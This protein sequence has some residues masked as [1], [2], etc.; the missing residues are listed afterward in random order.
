MLRLKAL[1]RWVMKLSRYTLYLAG[2][3]LIIMCV[4]AFTSLPFWA[5]YRLGTGYQ[6]DYHTAKTL[7]ILGGGGYPSESTLMRLW[8]TNEFAQRDPMLKVLIS[9]PGKIDDLSSTVMKM[10]QNLIDNGIDSTRIILEPVGLNTRHQAL[11]AFELYKKGF[12]EEPLVL[13]SSPE[14]IFRSVRCFRKVGF[15]EVS[16]QPTLE[17]MLETDLKITNQKLGGKT[18]VPNVG[19]SIPLRYSFWNYLKYEVDVAREYLAIAYYK[20]KGWI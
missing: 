3:L 9:T 2:G 16:G 14:H 15:I 19:S 10:R 6:P 20:L 17:T 18:G 8:F 4:L 7:V 11:L 5:R 1:L 12:F 13:V